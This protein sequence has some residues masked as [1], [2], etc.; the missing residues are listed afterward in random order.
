[1][2]KLLLF[3][4]L[5]QGSIAE[6]TQLADPRAMSSSEWRSWVKAQ[7][8]DI[9]GMGE[10]ASQFGPF[11]GGFFERLDLLAFAQGKRIQV[12]HR[13]L[14]M[15]PGAKGV[16]AQGSS[17]CR[18]EVD[19]VVVGNQL[20]ERRDYLIVGIQAAWHPR[21][22]PILVQAGPFQFK[23]KDSKPYLS[24]GTSWQA[25][26]EDFT[27]HLELVAAK[28]PRSLKGFD[29]L[30]GAIRLVVPQQLLWLE[31]GGIRESEV[32]V[33]QV[34]K[35]KI[36]RLRTQVTSK[37]VSLEVEIWPGP[38]EYQLDSYQES[39]LTGLASMVGPDNVKRNADGQQILESGE[40]K[41]RVRYDWLTS[42]ELPLQ[43]QQGN[44]RLVLR[45][46]DNY[47]E[48]EAR[49]KFGALELP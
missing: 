17:L 6:R 11:S 5:G 28:P 31:L 49:L 8:V 4:S 1:M 37:R 43:D 16:I 34:G 25:V 24:R 9:A 22:H 32:A 40:G 30:E 33:H 19:S 35:T 21:L 27:A 13:S 46:G 7:G 38:S 14:Q 48:I 39:I 42:R 2:L 23:S 12:R 41:M 15:V 18:G 20:D 10:S 36:K 47:K 3:L 45:I 29:S 44:Q 26:E